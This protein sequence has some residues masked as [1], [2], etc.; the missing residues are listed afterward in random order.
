MEGIWYG[1]YVA[2]VGTRLF[3]MHGVVLS[4][5]FACKFVISNNAELY[6]IWDRIG[7]RT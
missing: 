3:C 4:W 6:N 2:D 1:Y 5:T 7:F